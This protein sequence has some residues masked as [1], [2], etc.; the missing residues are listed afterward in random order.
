MTTLKYLPESFTNLV[1]ILNYDPE[2]EDLKEI[3]FNI[4]TSQWR[5]SNVLIVPRYCLKH[6]PDKLYL[7]KAHWGPAEY[8]IILIN[9]NQNLRIRQSLYNDNITFE[10]VN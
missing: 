1:R 8:P 9:P 7:D 5:N 10:L 2:E 3:E 4:D 6:G